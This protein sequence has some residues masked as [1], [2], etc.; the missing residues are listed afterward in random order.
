RTPRSWPPRRRPA[1]LQRSRQREGA[2]SSRSFLQMDSFEMSAGGGTAAESQYKAR[3]PTLARRPALVALKLRHEAQALASRRV[4][5]AEVRG[6]PGRR[7]AA[8]RLAL[9]RDASGD[10]GRE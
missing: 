1:P 6:K 3:R 9:R 5:A 10:R 7:G 4:R 8:C 2:L